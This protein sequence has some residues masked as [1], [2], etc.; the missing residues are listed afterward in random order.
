MS[1]RSW[2]K[3]WRSEARELVVE[4]T[5]LDVSVCVCE[6]LVEIEILN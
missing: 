5:S 1:L 4:Y 6:F 3:F 2:K